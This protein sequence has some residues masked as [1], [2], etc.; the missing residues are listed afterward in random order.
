MSS[1]HYSNVDQL[2]KDKLILD[3]NKFL[4]EIMVP[5]FIH[6]TFFIMQA[7]VGITLPAN[8]STRKEPS[9]RNL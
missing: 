9:S 6:G 1:R 2:I 5:G 4:T 7:T 3:N 8:N